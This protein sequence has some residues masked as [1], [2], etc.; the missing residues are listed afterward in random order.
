MYYYNDGGTK[1][2]QNKHMYLD[3]DMIDFE[4]YAQPRHI[5]MPRLLYVLEVY[6]VIE[7]Y[8]P[9]RRFLAVFSSR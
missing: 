6:L 1:S 5:D 9:S 8:I 4:K 2:K 7:L 3:I